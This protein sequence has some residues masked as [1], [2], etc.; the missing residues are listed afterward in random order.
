[1]QRVTPGNG[2]LCHAMVTNFLKQY[3]TKS[4]AFGEAI[5]PPYDEMV[6]TALSAPGFRRK[7]EPSVCLTFV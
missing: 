1:M 6:T 7:T 5:R 3:W 4:Q 2:Q